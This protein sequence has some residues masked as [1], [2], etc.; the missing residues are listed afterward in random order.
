[1]PVQ[2]HAHDYDVVQAKGL[3]KF[4]Q[5]EGST[6]AHVDIMAGKGGKS[7]VVTSNLRRCIETVMV[8]LW[9]RFQKS[10][11]QII[12][13]SDLQEA[14][15]NVDTFSLSS[16]MGLPPLKTLPTLLG[17]PED[18]VTSKLQMTGNAGQKKLFESGLVR[19]Q[20]FAAWC[21]DS[22]NTK[23]GDA[24][25]IVSG[26][27]LFFRTLFLA[28]MPRG[29][30]HEAKKLKIVNAGA[31]AITLERGIVDGVTVY[32]IDPASVKVVYGGFGK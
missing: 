1:M 10:E 27:S 12:V 6:N 18:K 14:S 19:L 32:R 11:E 31:V 29:V 3:Q 24:T 30:Q 8:G 28:Y 20:R 25:I 23:A 2:H 15:A 7:I 9:P 21:F 17:C 5:G 16:P 13:L 26:H 22:P 4:I